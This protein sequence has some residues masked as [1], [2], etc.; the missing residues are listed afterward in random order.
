MIRFS[1]ILLSLVA[2]ILLLPLFLITMIILKFTGEGKVFFLQKRV[3]IHNSEFQVFKFVT[4]RQDSES[5]GTG[6]Y[7]AKGDPRIL[8]IGNF[9][10]KTKINELPQLI[11]V[12]R[13]D[14]S[15]VGPRPLIRQTFDLYN[16][17]TINT[18]SRV[19]PG[20]TGIGSIVFR[21]EESLF[22]VTKYDSLE[23]FYSIEITPRKAAL[24]IWFVENLNFWTYLKIILGTSIVVFFPTIR[25]EKRLFKNLP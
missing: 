21:D 24:E 9:L 1:D 2:L 17:E 6:I 11:N 5:T 10:R 8:P 7:T 15:L 4:M 14:M 16:E 23:E 3:G 13:G 22:D 25:I 19:K 18:L 12:L 20:I